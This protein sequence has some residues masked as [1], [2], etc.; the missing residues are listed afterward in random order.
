MYVRLINGG[1]SAL[2]MKCKSVWYNYRFST[3]ES[4]NKWSVNSKI[5]I[6]RIFSKN[7]LHK[8][9]IDVFVYSI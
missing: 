6:V 1:D 3:L 5:Y 7:E 9:H 2:D 4:Q 8:T